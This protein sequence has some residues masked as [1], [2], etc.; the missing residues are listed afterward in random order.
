MSISNE[1]YFSPKTV[2]SY[3]KNQTSHLNSNIQ[4]TDDLFPPNKNSILGLD[5]NGD[6]LDKDQWFN[7]P[8]IEDEVGDVNDIIWKRA[9]EIFG[10][11]FKVFE[12]KIEADDVQQGNLGICYFLS[13]IA[14]LAEFPQLIDELIR[15]KEANE[16]GYYEVLLFIDGKWV[17]VP[18]DDYFPCDKY[19]GKLKFTRTNGKEIWVILIEKAWA[20]VN[21]GYINISGGWTS[22]ALVTIS[23]F[24]CSKFAHKSANLDR[25]WAQITEADDS[26]DIM[27]CGTPSNIDLVHYEKVG[28]TPGHAYTLISAKSILH[29]GKKIRLVLV[30]NPHGRYYGVNTEWKGDWSDYSKLWTPELRE[31]LHFQSKDDGTFWMSYEDYLK[32]FES[33]EICDIFYNANFKYFEVVG[34]AIKRPQ[35][36]NLFL[37]ESSKVAI[38]VYRETFRFNRKRKDKNYPISIVIAKYDIN[39]YMLSSVDGKFCSD[40]TCE[41]VE[42][43][44]KG[45]YVVWVFYNHEKCNGIDIDEYRVRFASSEH[46]RVV[47]KGV[48]GEFKLI[49]E[50]ILSGCKEL[51]ADDIRKEPELTKTINGFKKTGIGCLLVAN[52]TMNR[53]LQIAKAK[54]TNVVGFGVLPPYN[55]DS[56]I[57]FEVLPGCYTVVLGMRTST[58]GSFGFNI[59]HS[60]ITSRCSSG[61][62]VL[63]DISSFISDLTDRE[64]SYHHCLVLFKQKMGKVIA[65][66]LKDIADKMED[67]YKKKMF[68]E[69]ERNSLFDE[70]LRKQY[71][72]VIEILLKLPKSMD[73]DEL[74]WKHNAF[75][76]DLYLGQV[77]NKGMKHGR[78]VMITRYSKYVG[79][80]V[81]DYQQGHGI[82]VNKD[83]T[84]YYEGNIE[85]GQMNGNGKLFLPKGER[86]EG[87]FVDGFYHGIGRYYY[88][89]GS[90]WEGLFEEGLQ[91]GEG[92]M[93]GEDGS[94]SRVTYDYGDIVGVEQFENELIP[95][96]RVKS[97]LNKLVKNYKN[98]DDEGVYKTEADID[99]LYLTE[100]E[101][102]REV[103]H[104]VLDSEY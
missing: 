24:A 101:V 50:I 39:T 72:D 80:W 53:K 74:T 100:S 82:I 97:V 21:G 87:I 66:F 79:L 54:L 34:N 68:E 3:W 6:F 57:A 81:N 65:R 44:E 75:G 43:L 32:Y 52:S 78:G 13:G 67:E 73:E 41:F 30:R 84:P 103:D 63:T 35:V 28:L 4:W 76:D 27:C 102:C 86:F 11:S 56:E 59:P 7:N 8:G 91:N 26:N 83:D 90:Y 95:R 5:Q 51:Y 60:I 96:P 36:F 40:D 18:V 37:E 55:K 62:M 104:F 61:K 23:S 16:K 38:S 46:F 88:A 20:K 93:Y 17:I 77:N 49:N 71:P 14:A 25:F 1:N 29:Q 69:I 99:S 89:D 47:H 12:G 70:G 85:N 45:H 15:T 64:R 94:Y 42:K 2:K 9:P 58:Y 31:H 92:M 10:N 48:D 22:E 98:Y 19:S 33:T